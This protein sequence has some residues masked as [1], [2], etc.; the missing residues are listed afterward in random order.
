MSAVAI[1][2]ALLVA[3][4]P[5]TAIIPAA[6]IFAGIIPQGQLLPAI[7]ITEV[8]SYELDTVARQQSTTSN[9]SRVQVT[10]VAR[11]LFDQK[12]TIAAAK[13]GPGV[14]RGVWG[15]FTVLSVLPGGVGPDLNNLDD[16]GIYEQSRDFLVTFVEPN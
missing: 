4:T 16:D 14:H 2:H 11:S 3:H 9:R 10:V 7:S 5:L 8:D 1:M 15:G 13:L 6:R 12:R